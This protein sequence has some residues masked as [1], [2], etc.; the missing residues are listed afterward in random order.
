M[1]D[2][3]T[4]SRFVSTPWVG[5]FSDHAEVGGF[6]IPLYGEVGWMIDDELVLYWRGRIQTAE[7][8]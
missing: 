5:T 4:E 2:R 1:R 3:A 8:R 6:R 7:Y